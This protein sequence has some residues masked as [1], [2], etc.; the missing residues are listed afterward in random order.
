MQL[1]RIFTITL[2][3]LL[4]SSF[5]LLPSPRV[6]GEDADSPQLPRAL[7][8]EEVAKKVQPSLASITVNGRDGG[9]LGI[10]TGFVVSADGLIATNLHVIGQGSTFAVELFDG[11]DLE[12]RDVH[13]SDHG[14]DLAVIRV[15]P[16]GK[17][18]EPLGLGDSAAI[19]QGAAV[20]AMGNPLGLK[21]SVV[22]GILS[23]RREINGHS[24]LQLAMPIEPGNSGG[25][26]L[27]MQA[28]VVGLVN[29]KSAVNDN[30]GFAIEVNSLKSLLE[31]PNPVSIGR[32]TT[33]G[34]LDNRR[35][36]P[37]LGAS[38]RQRAGRILVSG[39]G[40]GFGGRSICLYQQQ[41][42]EVPFEISVQVR[43]KD[44]SGAAGLVFH[45]DGED[46][47]YGFYPSN[48]Q[49]RLTCFN[50]PTV[51][52]WQILEDRPSPDYQ[53]G[54]WNRLKVR[55]EADKF[56]CYV[57][58]QVIYE[59]HDTTFRSGKV[60]LAKFRNTEAEF[61]QF[62]LAK[63]IATVAPAGLE[64]LRSEIASLSDPSK[65][66]P[67][68]LAS[69][70]KSPD[71]AVTSLRKQAT[72]LE[73]RAAGLRRLAS[74]VHVSRVTAA[75]AELIADR[76]QGFDLLRASLL[77]AK[78]DEEDIDVEGYVSEVDRMAA[79]IQQPLAKD[80]DPPTRLAALNEYLFKQNGFHGARFEYYHRA[81][82][83]LNRVIDDRAGLPITLSVLYIE[84][85]RRLGLEVEGVGM[86]S[87]FVVRFLPGKG[88]PQLI[89]VF[90]RGKPISREDAAA[91]V[92][93]NSSTELRDEHLAAQTPR[94]IINRVLA[95]LWGVAERERDLESMLRYAE[96]MVAVDPQSLQSRLNRAVLRGE[97]GR[98]A[99]AIADF[100][101]VIEQ[102]PP[103]VDL[104][105]VRR[106]RD[107]L[108]GQ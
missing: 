46:K 40:S 99:A 79:E 11:T 45:A 5:C 30:L 62:Q 41:P 69:W 100:D 95:N 59:S 2:L 78:L 10:G 108:A 61:K 51:Y 23:A 42:P 76:D 74:D 44:E 26:V 9:Q 33:I 21:H 38:W 55:I 1:S 37:L 65:I 15:D 106:L 31:K 14:L 57:N 22:A 84:V 92:R 29:M 72:S 101:W 34:G 43:L 73:A 104:E 63:E 36:K 94:Q 97:T 19:Q 67:E 93:E 56:T 28:N 27:D 91:I 68:Q 98:K 60:G 32:W 18:L 81:N 53:L 16:K 39:S 49:L 102:Q 6:F 89:D 96:A 24:M 88:D 35:W 80:A 86:P 48:G 13:A 77:I 17:K 66:D 20:V 70:A 75:L 47:H 58:D 103:G 64:E 107:R 50:G 4:H 71:L 90:D 85:A 52:Q 8:V 54:D 3:F 105:V 82:S 25:P 7:T 87:H 83:Y 12:V